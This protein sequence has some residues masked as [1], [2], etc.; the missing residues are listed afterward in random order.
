MAAAMHRCVALGVLALAGTLVHAQELH[1]CRAPDGSL[2]YQDTPCAREA[3]SLAVPSIDPAPYYV[4][5]VPEPAAIASEPAGAPRANPPRER[6]PPPLLFRCTKAEGDDYVSDTPY[7]APRAVPLW[8]IEG[9]APTFGPGLGEAGGQ[10]TWVQDVCRRMGR[11]ELCE[12]W[13]KRLD[14][15]RGERS[16]AFKDT[17]PALDIE[18]QRLRMDIDEYCR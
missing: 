9:L 7:T 17:R 1:K 13:R 4:A 8:T 16:R 6:S 12:H 3:T 10:Y 15:V 2:S 11:R 14:I 5:P 18:Y